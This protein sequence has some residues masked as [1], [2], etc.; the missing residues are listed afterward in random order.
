MKDI[1]AA[2]LFLMSSNADG[3]TLSCSRMQQLRG[4]HLLDLLVDVE[5]EREEQRVPDAALHRQVREH[6][7]QRVPAGGYVM[8]GMQ[9]TKI[10]NR[11]TPSASKVS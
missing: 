2:T 3:T 6:P 11:T 9:Q 5:S 4:V 7:Q 1:A 10:C 8:R